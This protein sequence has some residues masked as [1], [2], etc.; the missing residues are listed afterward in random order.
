VSRKL[1][2]SRDYRASHRGDK[3]FAKFLTQETLTS[4]GAKHWH[5]RD[6][7]AEL[8]HTLLKST[9]VE[10]DQLELKNAL[11]GLLHGKSFCRQLADVAGYKID[12]VWGCRDN[13]TAK[14]S[15]RIIAS[16]P[17][18]AP[19]LDRIFADHIAASISDT[20]Q[21]PDPI[22]D[23]LGLL[24]Q[25]RVDAAR[26]KKTIAESPL[27]ALFDFPSRDGRRMGHTILALPLI[28]SSKK[29]AKR[30]VAAIVTDLLGSAAT[31]ADQR[32]LKELLRNFF[33]QSGN[34]HRHPLY[35]N[36]GQAIALRVD[37][38]TMVH[39]PA[40]AKYLDRRFAAPIAARVAKLT[41]S[42]GAAPSDEVETEKTSLDAMLDVRAQMAVKIQSHPIQQVLDVR[43]WVKDDA[44]LWTEPL[45]TSY[46]SPCQAQVTELLTELR[47]AATSDAD[48]QAL[49]QAIGKG[50]GRF[51]FCNELG[52]VA[53]QQSSQAG[54]TAKELAKDY[55]LGKVLDRLF[56]A[57]IAQYVD[58]HIAAA[59]DGSAPSEVMGGRVELLVK[60]R[61]DMKLVEAKVAAWNGASPAR[62]TQRAAKAQHLVD[63][64]ARMSAQL[65]SPAAAGNHQRAVQDLAGHVTFASDAERDSVFAALN[66]A[67]DGKVNPDCKPGTEFMHGWP[68]SK[69]AAVALDQA[70]LY[71]R[72][73]KHMAVAPPAPV[74]P[75]PSK[76]MW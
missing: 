47:Q 48:Q 1:C 60:A 19:I 13:L 69:D 52:D 23:G 75:T 64:R 71:E 54:V 42:S 38:S 74:D 70:I 39:D 31:P 35:W 67:K 43:A 61:A 15:A 34:S 7:A 32:V 8:L 58:A 72:S 51:Y 12:A 21:S 56:P 6:R 41:D 65:R 14:N 50:L 45:E 37:V 53:H 46:G 29:C 27:R 36:E 57:Q 16:E 68:L 24:V 30:E 3:T 49:R 76:S 9:T 26:R 10:A 17:T 40:I 2:F 18:I 33:N 20:A 5:G 28:D 55:Q 44:A 66:Y 62:Q 22:P 59:G 25:H 11:N 63:A 4:T 73:R